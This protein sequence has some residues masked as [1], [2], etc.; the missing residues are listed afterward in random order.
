MIRTLPEQTAIDTNFR[1]SDNAALTSIGQTGKENQQVRNYSQRLR[2][3]FQEITDSGDTTK[4]TED[5]S[6]GPAK[7]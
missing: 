6:D 4:D 5:R 2:V 3:L 1:A 7:P